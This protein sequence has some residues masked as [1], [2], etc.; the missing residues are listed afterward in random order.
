[1]KKDNNKQN[2]GSSSILG[3]KTADIAGLSTEELNDN[4]TAI[5]ML[6]HYYRQLIEENNTLKNYNNTLKTY[7]DAYNR[8]KSNSG[9]GVVLLLISNI[10]IGFGVNLLSVD[11]IWPGVSSLIIGVSLAFTG[12][13]FSFKKS[14]N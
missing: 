12:I 14:A 9:I 3:L 13:Y 1:M 7:V 11:N 6:L 5:K 2:K 8:Q 4:P 10:S